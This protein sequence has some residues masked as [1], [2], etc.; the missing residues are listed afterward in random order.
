MHGEAMV[1]CV[2]P[3]ITDE[4]NCQSEKAENKTYKE[5][6]VEDGANSSEIAAKETNNS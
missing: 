6:N 2:K 4:E 1:N 3:T 5:D